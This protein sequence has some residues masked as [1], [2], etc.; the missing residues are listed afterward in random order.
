M[1]QSP[2]LTA[3]LLAAVLLLAATLSRAQAFPPRPLP[4]EAVAEKTIR[5]LADRVALTPGEIDAMRP[6]LVHSIRKRQALVRARMAEKSGAKAL[7]AL[8]DDLRALARDTDARLSA[9]LPPDTL[10]AVRAAME[11]RR[12]EARAR[13]AAARRGS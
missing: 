5:D 13:L 12:K 9:V 7:L 2:L 11:A 10:T 3:L 4:P 8:R 1:R 6:I